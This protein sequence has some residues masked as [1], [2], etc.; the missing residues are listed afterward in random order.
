MFF[1]VFSGEIP[2]S[3]P[4]AVQRQKAPIFSL[5]NQTSLCIRT[6]NY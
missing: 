3:F 6:E 1:N 4:W 2:G 5:L